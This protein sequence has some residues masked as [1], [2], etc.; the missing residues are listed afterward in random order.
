MVSSVSKVL[1]RSVFLAK[2]LRVCATVRLVVA[3]NPFR[4]ISSK[5]AWMFRII[6]GVRVLVAGDIVLVG[7]PASCGGATRGLHKCVVKSVG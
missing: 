2:A 1:L 3:S 4:S 7:V 5:V 6:C